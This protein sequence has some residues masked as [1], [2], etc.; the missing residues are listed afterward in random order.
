MVKALCSDK[1]DVFYELAYRR[2][3][4]TISKIKGFKYDN[5]RLSTENVGKHLLLS[6]IL[7][8]QKG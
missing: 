2:I 1:E 5:L 7:L 3:L 4:R 8:F 6:E